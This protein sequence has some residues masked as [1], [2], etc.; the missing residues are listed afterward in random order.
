[1]LRYISIRSNRYKTHPD[2]RKRKQDH[3]DAS[4]IMCWNGRECPDQEHLPRRRALWDGEPGPVP[5]DKRVEGDAAAQSRHDL[6]EPPPVPPVLLGRWLLQQPTV[7]G[8]ERP[9]HPAGNRVL[10]RQKAI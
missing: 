10:A 9:G 8:W 4:R 2:A 6:R 1:M 5:N 7:P 3:G